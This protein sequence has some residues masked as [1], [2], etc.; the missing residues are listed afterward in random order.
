M[1]NI[2]EGIYA[3]C[4]LSQYSLDC[5]FPAR[6]FTLNGWI[7]LL[8]KHLNEYSDL[9]SACTLHEVTCLYSL[10]VDRDIPPLFMSTTSL[11]TTYGGANLSQGLQE[12]RV[13]IMS[14]K[15]ILFV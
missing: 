14:L 2:S 12:H 7:C 3:T 5:V 8:P 13:W 11:L 10:H 6:G 1:L 9:K 4:S 15:S